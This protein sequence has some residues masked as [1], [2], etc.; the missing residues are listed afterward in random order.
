MTSSNAEAIKPLLTK[1]CAG[2][3]LSSDETQA[4]F[5]SIMSGSLSSAQ[6]A[7]FL[8]AMKVRGETVEELVGAV[9]VMRSK[10]MPVALPAPL[11]NG[12]MDIV[13]TGGDGKGSYNVSTATAFVVA[14]AGVPVAKH[15]NRALSSRSGAADV[16]KALGVT[17][18]LSPEQIAV[19]IKEANIG[20]M[21]AP[22]HHTAMKHVG[23]TRSELGQ[24]TIFNLIGPLS[25]PASVKRQLVGVY[26]ERWLMPIAETLRELGCEAAWVVHGSDGMDE[27]TTTGTTHVAKLEEGSI[28]MAVIDPRDVD[29][30]LVSEDALVGGDADQNAAALRA[31]LS[32]EPGPYADIVAL[33]AAA[34]LCVAGNVT[35]LQKGVVKAKD[36]LASKAGLEVL[37]N[38]VSISCG[39]S[40]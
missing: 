25:N 32:G 16:L 9:R 21:F 2:E 6:I 15:G 23:P 3:A 5:T 12:A 8:I 38:L 17:I 30:D 10:M 4:A 11:A 37:N 7:A 14:A 28:R 40:S 13:G 20:F 1:V 24:R 34:S 35:T 22:A 33:N 39:T 26:D 29:L 18:D 36:V 19:C 27:I 31:V